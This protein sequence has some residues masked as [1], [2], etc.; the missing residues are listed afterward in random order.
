MMNDLNSRV[1]EALDRT[2]IMAL[3][4]VGPDGSWT[5]PVQYHADDQLNLFFMSMP[6][7]RHVANIKHNPH[8][9]LAIYSFPGPPGGNLGLQIKGTAEHLAEQST[10]GSWQQFKI[11]PEEAWC[12]DSRITRERQRIDLQHLEIAIDSQ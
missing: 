5:S 1:Q 11:T 7:A 3:S 6:N 12:F 10:P 4:T 8:V 9:S 2:E